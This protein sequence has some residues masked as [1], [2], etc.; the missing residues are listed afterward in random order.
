M[1]QSHLLRN[2][3]MAARLERIVQ[4]A[5]ESGT[6]SES[7][8]S[9]LISNAVRLVSPDTAAGGMGRHFKAMCVV[10]QQ[11]AASEI[12]PFNIPDDLMAQEEAEYAAQGAEKQKAANGASGGANLL[13]GAAQLPY[14]DPLPKAT[15]HLFS[16]APVE[17]PKP[18]QQ[19]TATEQATASSTTQ[20]RAAAREAAA[21]LAKA[22]AEREAAEAAA[23]AATK[24]G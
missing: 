4:R 17:T 16:S 20:R 11:L 3:N 15:E 22:R 12:V 13:F 5:V 21:Q 8:I 18:K 1:T 24:S 6:L 14:A 9:D 10:S 19:L 7:Q 2:L 23:K